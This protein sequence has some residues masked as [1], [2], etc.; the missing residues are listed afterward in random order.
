MPN[1]V[2]QKAAVAMAAQITKNGI[3]ITYERDADSVTL[4]AMQGESSHQTFNP[5]GI[6][7]NIHSHDFLCPTEDLVLSGNPVTPQRGDR[8][9]VIDAVDGTTRIY[10]VYPPADS[11]DTHTPEDDYHR[12][13]RVYTRMI[14]GRSD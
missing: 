2:L 1:P 4:I 12:I 3:S 7:V 5:H 13:V 9:T 11:M 6:F 10:E 8:I 14:N